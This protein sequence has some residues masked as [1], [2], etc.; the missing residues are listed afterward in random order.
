[1]S[2]NRSPFAYLPAPRDQGPSRGFDRRRLVAAALGG[3]LVAHATRS[4][5][6]ARQ[7]AAGLL[8]AAAAA[9]AKLRSFH[10]ALLT[11]QGVTE[12][13]EGVE[14]VRLEGDV[15]RP[16]RFAATIEAR[17]ATLDVALD[18]VGIGPRLWVSDPTG[19][20]VEV[21]LEA[22]GGGVDRALAWLA[23]PDR[24]WLAGLAIVADPVVVGEN[25]IDGEP[26]TRIDGTIDFGRVLGLGDAALA[27][28]TPAA[29][30]LSAVLGG[31]LPVSLWLSADNRLRRLEVEGQLLAADAANVVRRLDLSRFDEPVTI[32]PPDA[33]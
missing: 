11:P 15:V 27:R 33:G 1:M 5:R 16:D 17:A 10:F 6:A 12:I 25:A 2:T 26:V 21:P 7:D 29:G 23:N 13:V 30:P 22:A 31:P 32:A 28:T 4:V 14:L 19:G 18:V 24:L 9:M 3:I 20:F 8:A